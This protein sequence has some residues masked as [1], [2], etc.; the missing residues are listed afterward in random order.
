M[1]IA[2]DRA[3]RALQRRGMVLVCDLDGTLATDVARRHLRPRANSACLDGVA[4]EQ[5][6][7]Y[8]DPKLVALDEPVSGA[9]ELLGS[10]VASPGA[11]RLLLVTA[12]W[13]SLW[14]VTTQWLGRH[15][16]NV[17][18]FLLM[19]KRSDTRPSVDVKLDLVRTY[20]GAAQGGVWLDD[21]PRMLLAAERAGFVA[22]K[23]PEVFAATE[24]PT[25]IGNVVPARR[26]AWCHPELPESA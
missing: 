18:P 4:P 23:A 25:P 14:R 15:Y 9:A 20:G 12:R 2:L 11:P 16:P 22:L 7:R 1:S 8:M 21:D 6:E 5:I 26:C 13:N 3:K 24:A 10:L 19:R 17:R